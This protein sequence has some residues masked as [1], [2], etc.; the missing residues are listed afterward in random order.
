MAENTSIRPPQPFHPV[1][2]KRPACELGQRLS[3]VIVAQRRDFK[4]SH[5]VSLGIRFG[6]GNAYRPFKFQVKSVTNKNFRHARSMLN[7]DTTSRFEITN[8]GMEILFVKNIPPRLLFASG[9]FHRKTICWSSHRP[10]GDPGHLESR[11]AILCK[12]VPVRMYPT[13]EDELSYRLLAMW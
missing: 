13:T 11:I 8:K 12:T 9:Q 7:K 5:T 4:E 3:Y 1:S 10:E 2:P 6:L